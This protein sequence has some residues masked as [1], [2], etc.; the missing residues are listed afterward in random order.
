MEGVH[1]G[2]A[3][4][5]PGRSEHGSSQPP[6]GASEGREPSPG[7]QLLTRAPTRAGEAAHCRVRVGARTRGEGPLVPRKSQPSVPEGGRAAEGRGGEETERRPARNGW[8][9]TRDPSASHTPRP[10]RGWGWGWGRGSREGGGRTYSAVLLREEVGAVVQ[11]FLQGRR[12]PGRQG[13]GRS[14]GDTKGDISAR[15]AGPPKPAPRPRP[16]PRAGG[17]APLEN[18]HHH[19]CSEARAS[20]GALRTAGPEGDQG[21]GR[22]GATGGRAF[23]EAPPTRRRGWGPAAWE[24]GGRAFCQ[25]SEHPKALDP[26][27]GDRQLE[28]GGLWPGKAEGP[29]GSCP[30]LFPGGLRRQTKPA[31]SRPPPSGSRSKSSKLCLVPQDK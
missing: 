27:G 25:R 15:P 22:G 23:Q 21:G 28:D 13:K 1:T 16:P 8:R 26:L 12:G 14:E 19:G 11:A 31:P 17:S 7:L 20:A 24:Q 2:E 18:T 10:R 29:W 6:R 30:V 4:V 9:A 3:R 5:P